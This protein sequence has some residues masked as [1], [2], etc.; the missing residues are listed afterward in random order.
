MPPRLLNRKSGIV[1]ADASKAIRPI[2]QSI[3]KEQ[4]YVNTI[5]VD[6][7]KEAFHTIQNQ[8]ISWVL[9]H[10]DYKNPNN[11]FRLLKKIAK[12]P[13]D[14]RPVVS[15]MV[16]EFELPLLPLAYTLGLFSHHVKPISQ[17]NLAEGIAEAIDRTTF[18]NNETYTAAHFLRSLLTREKNFYELVN[19]EEDMLRALGHEHKQFINLA[20]AHIKTGAKEKAISSLQQAVIINPMLIGEAD[21]IAQRNFEKSLHELQEE[22]LLDKAIIVDHDDAE[23]QSLSEAL[24]KLGVQE[25]QHFDNPTDALTFYKENPDFDVL[26]S[27]WRLRGMPGNIFLQRAR[28]EVDSSTL[29][30]LFTSLVKDHD[31]AF[32]EEM[33]VAKVIPKPLSEE[34]FLSSLIQALKENRY[35]SKATSLTRKIRVYLNCGNKEEATH[36]A[37]R[38]FADKTIPE[39]LKLPI[40]AELAFMEKKYK[41]ALSFAVDSVKQSGVS[42]F[43]LNIMGKCFMAEGQFRKALQCFNKA[44]AMSPENLERLCH[45]AEAHSELGEDRFAMRDMRQLQKLAPDAEIVQNTAVKVATN[46][47]EPEA[48]SSLM[49]QMGDISHLISFW[50]NQAV[51]YA[52]NSEYMQAMETY[53]KALRALDESNHSN[54]ATAIR[55]NL[56]LCHA[57]KGNTNEVNKILKLISDSE[58]DSPVMKKISSLQH[59]TIQS[60]KSGKPIKLNEAENEV[61]EENE[62]SH[63]DIDSLAPP[64]TIEPGEYCL[65]GVYQTRQIYSEE[66]SKSLE[67]EDF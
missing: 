4:G 23:V 54:Q 2:A 38:L 46:S 55:Y 31:K 62:L 5:L 41:M 65:L 34:F 30:L 25:I 43:L 53:E 56:A 67:I 8:D 6:E 28:Q 3:F 27:E 15:F 32:L 40:R 66:V 24:K 35:P 14:K 45:I 33:G 29:F 50:N 20:N 10:L 59:K 44:K 58:D 47:D 37:N 57:R 1:I 52:K 7:N 51:T 26:I 39:K 11:G 64:P 49:D 13:E 12:M 9:C 42:I 63:V 36:L 48:A 18:Y 22:R 21:L 16:N 61:T 19:L 17:R 60:I